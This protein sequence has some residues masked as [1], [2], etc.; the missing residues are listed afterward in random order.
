[1]KGSSKVLIGVGLG[2]VAG[3]VA[4]YFLASAEGQ[5]FQ[6]KTKEQ[7]DQLGTD[8]KK[9]LKNNAGTAAEKLGEATNS[10][11]KWVSEASETIKEKV[12]NTSDKVED[13]A[14]EVVEEV[15]E[16]FQSGVEKARRNI[17]E[18]TNDVG[19]LA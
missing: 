10:A 5:E 8:L 1:M 19:D 4:G 9:S 6:R 16:D 11:K 15:V 12:S 2:I 17:E 3:G 14:E 18:R 7:L 13:A